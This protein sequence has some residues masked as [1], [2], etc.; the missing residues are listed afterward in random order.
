MAKHMESR[1]YFE[2]TVGGLSMTFV[3]VRGPGQADADGADAAWILFHER[4]LVVV[5]HHDLCVRLDQMDSL[6][7]SLVEIRK[8]MWT[9]DAPELPK[10]TIKMS[11][12]EEIE[13]MILGRHISREEAERL[14]SLLDAAIKPEDDDLP[15]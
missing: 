3:L 2:Q 7:A 8:L 11:D 12:A 15:F 1:E 13:A 4:E 10:D 6:I 5:P 14:K 9:F